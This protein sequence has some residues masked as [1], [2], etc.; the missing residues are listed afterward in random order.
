LGEGMG[1]DQG[2][3]SGPLEEV[4]KWARGVTKGRSDEWKKVA[5]N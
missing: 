4:R 3:A 5:G 1:G 2:G